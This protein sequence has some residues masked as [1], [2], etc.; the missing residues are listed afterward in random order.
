[1]WDNK[2]KKLV[3]QLEETWIIKSYLPLEIVIFWMK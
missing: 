3:Q 2:H 1:M